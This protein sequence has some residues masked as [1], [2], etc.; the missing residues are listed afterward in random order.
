M[1]TFW[2]GF[3][4]GLHNAFKF[5]YRMYFQQSAQYEH[6]EAFHH[7][8]FAGCF[9]GVDMVGCYVSSRGFVEN[10][11]TVVNDVTTAFYLRLEFVERGL[12]Q[13]DSRVITAEDR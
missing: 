7:F 4:Q 5:D 11:E 13:N 12:V 3:P 6:I 8:H 1:V 10:T 2:Q 9:H